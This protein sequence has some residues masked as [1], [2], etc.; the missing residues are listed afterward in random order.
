MN[1]SN[2]S[3]IHELVNL[4]LNH[5]YVDLLE[6]PFSYTTVDIGYRD[7][8]IFPGWPMEIETNFRLIF[9]TDRKV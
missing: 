2:Y 4:G 9:F 1:Y 7:I 3:L 6:Q 8:Q 5:M